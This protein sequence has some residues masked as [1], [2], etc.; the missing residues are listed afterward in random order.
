MRDLGVPMIDS[1]PVLRATGDPMG[2]YPFR[3]ESDLTPQGY[4]IL[5]RLIG[6]GLAPAGHGDGR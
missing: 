5:A 2:L 1:E 4:A 6:D 3:I